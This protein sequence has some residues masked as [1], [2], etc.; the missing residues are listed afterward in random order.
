MTCLSS[1]QR[2]IQNLAKS[3]ENMNII[4]IFEMKKN[5]KKRQIHNSF[6]DSIAF[7]FEYLKDIK[8][9]GKIGINAL[10]FAK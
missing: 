3:C 2:H 6:I 10:Y 8:L 7:T 9:K 4:L 1:I 5:N